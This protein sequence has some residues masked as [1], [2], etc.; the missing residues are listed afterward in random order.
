MEKYKYTFLSIQ[1][2]DE[3]CQNFGK[4]MLIS[5]LLKMVQDVLTS[6]LSTGRLTWLPKTEWRWNEACLVSLLQV[7]FVWG[8]Q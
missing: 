1:L 7:F 2:L 5:K 6:L 3:P 8:E 4:S